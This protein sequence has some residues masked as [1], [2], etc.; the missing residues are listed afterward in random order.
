MSAHDSIHDPVVRALQ[1]DGWTVTH[2]PLTLEFGDLYLFVDVGAERA[3]AAE[4]GSERIAVEVKS[5]TNKSKVADLQQAVGQYAVYRSVLR[6]VEPGRTLYL[7][8]PSEAYNG[9]FSSQVGEAVRADFGVQ[10]VVVDVAAEEVISW[11]T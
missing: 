5:F 9:V 2:D 1:K 11:I 6:R 7:A 4:R 8:V 3:L 10:L